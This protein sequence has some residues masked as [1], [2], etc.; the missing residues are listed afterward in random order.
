M[1]QAKICGGKR[2]GAIIPVAPFQCLEGCPEPGSEIAV[3]DRKSI[4]TLNPRDAGQKT[5]KA[6]VHHDTDAARLLSGHKS[7]GAVDR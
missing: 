4:P 6:T 7:A 3:P 1:G 5:G 2:S